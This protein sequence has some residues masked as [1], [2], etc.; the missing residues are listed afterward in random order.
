MWVGWVTPDYHQHDMNFDLSKVRAV[1]VT[2]GDEQG[3]VHSRCWDGWR[4]WE[5]GGRRWAPGSE[6][7]LLLLSF[8]LFSS[9]DLLCFFPPPVLF[10][11]VLLH[12]LLLFSSRLPLSMLPPFSVLSSCSPFF[13]FQNAPPPAF[14]NSSSKGLRVWGEGFQCSCLQVV[15]VWGWALRSWYS[16][17]SGMRVSRVQ[18]ASAED[19]CTDHPCLLQPQVQQ[20]LHGVG[21]GLREPWAAGP[22]QPHGPY[23]WLPGG[24]GHWPNDL[25]N[26]WQREQHLFPG[27]PSP[28]QLSNSTLMSQHAGT[29]FPDTPGSQT[30]ERQD[31]NNI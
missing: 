14:K 13:F 18:S 6:A 23:H 30:P 3:N 19:P 15:G 25:Y 26:Q 5:A 22:D 8:C 10:P 11:F 31:K 9:N 17:S 21:W 28:L 4:M 29:T 12:L 20:L 24:L 27:E 1:T 2:M 16:R 7:S